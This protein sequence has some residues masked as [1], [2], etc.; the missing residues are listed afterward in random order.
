M[1]L[2]REASTS[3]R[4]KI[5]RTKMTTYVEISEA[6]VIGGY[7]SEADKDAA[8][9]ILADAL[10]VEAAEEVEAEAMD[11]YSDQEDLIAEAEVWEA[12]DELAGDYEGA[13]LDADT[14]ED[15]ENQKEIDKEVVLEAEALIDAACTDA[16]AALLAAALIDEANLE[17]VVAVIH[18]YNCG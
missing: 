10:I 6:L 16:G 15:A 11:D 7:L 12:E 5:R 9:D 2:K 3:S 17:P 13:D 4:S 18:E 14:I 1:L 8:A